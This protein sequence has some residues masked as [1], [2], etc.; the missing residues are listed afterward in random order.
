MFYKFWQICSCQKEW[1]FYYGGCGGGRD[2]ENEGKSKILLKKPKPK[3]NVFL[4]EGVDGYGR[5]EVGEK[6]MKDMEPIY[7]TIQNSN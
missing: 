3:N 4:S 6:Q 7:I 2:V 1:Y 5:E